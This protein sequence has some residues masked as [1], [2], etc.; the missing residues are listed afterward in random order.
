[1]A[2]AFANAMASAELTALSAGTA[3][4]ERLNPTVV[5]VME[6]VGMNM[7]GQAP[8]LLTPE[9]VESADLV[10]SMGCGV[11]ESC[12]VG[13]SD[14]EDWGLDDPKGQPVGEVREIREQIKRKVEA[15]VRSLTS[16][17][18]RARPA[19]AP[20]SARSPRCGRGSD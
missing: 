6:E 2:E 20:R 9:M 11:Q 8:T 17:E 10:I 13:L 3:P 1:M 19:E 14:A 5:K 16:P 4:G 18:G 12:P 7:S 15:L